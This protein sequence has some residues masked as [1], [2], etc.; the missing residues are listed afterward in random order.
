M[1]CQCEPQRHGDCHTVTPSEA[2]GPEN[3][4]QTSGASVHGVR[5][6]RA[7]ASVSGLCLTWPAQTGSYC[8][9]GLLERTGS[10]PRARQ[11]STFGS[12]SD[13]CKGGDSDPA[14][15]LQDGR[16]LV[17]VNLLRVFWVLH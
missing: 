7:A 15:Y 9:D 16:S 1:H 17:R 11:G 12:E 10:S 14:H 8:W 2:E 3:P 5:Q 4:R 13:I 6:A